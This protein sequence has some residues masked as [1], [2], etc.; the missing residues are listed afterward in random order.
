MAP[1]RDALLDSLSQPPSEPRARL[2]QSRDLG[3]P[4]PGVPVPV[5]VPPHRSRRGELDDRAG[6]DALDP[7][8]GRLLTRQL[9]RRRRLHEEFRQ[10]VQVERPAGLLVHEGSQAGAHGDCS[11]PCG[12]EERPAAHGIPLS[13]EALSRTVPDDQREL[14]LN[15]LQPLSAELPVGGQRQCGVGGVVQAP[16]RGKSSQEVP[17]VVNPTEEGRRRSGRGIP[18]ER[19]QRRAIPPRAIDPDQAGLWRTTRRTAKNEAAIHGSQVPHEGVAQQR[20]RSNGIG[21]PAGTSRNAPVPQ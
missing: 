1:L 16:R 12:P 15:R 7:L 20:S 19:H 8:E 9:V 3:P 11:L 2:F 5:N 6:A 21:W 14:A 18:G 17:P 10:R 4:D 13:P